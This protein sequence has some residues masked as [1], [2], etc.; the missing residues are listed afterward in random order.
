MPIG[1]ELPTK[2][3][4][5]NEIHSGYTV[6]DLQTADRLGLLYDVLIC[7]SRAHVNIAL[8]RIATEKGAAFDSFY[9]T[10]LEGRKITDE[11]TLR[12]L[13][14]SLLAAGTG[15]EYVKK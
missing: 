8:S 7:L 9:V 14:A 6:I 4:I 13:Q 15:G 10:D 11:T 3:I 1:M 2:L 5:S 12:Q